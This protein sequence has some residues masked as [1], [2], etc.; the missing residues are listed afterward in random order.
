MPSRL[1]YDALPLVPQAPAWERAVPKAMPPQLFNRVPIGP[2]T[3]RGGLY[4][5]LCLNE[6]SYTSPG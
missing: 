6:A 4:N 1:N 2:R 5:L 3:A